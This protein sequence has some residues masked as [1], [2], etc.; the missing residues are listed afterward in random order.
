MSG[1]IVTTHRCNALTFQTNGVI[2]STM[3]RDAAK[4]INSEGTQIY[5]GIDGHEVLSSQGNYSR[6]VIRQ[7][8]LVTIQAW[9]SLR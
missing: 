7:F 5:L 1:L 8:G 9:S 3:G 4:L 6:A 2:S